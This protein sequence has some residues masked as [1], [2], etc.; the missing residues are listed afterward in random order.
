MFKS[1]SILR[2]ALAALVIL[3]LLP[4]CAPAEEMAPQVYIA[5]DRVNMLPLAGAIAYQAE[6]AGSSVDMLSIFTPKDGTFYSSK[7]DCTLSDGLQLFEGKKLSASDKVSHISNFLRDFAHNADFSSPQTEVYILSG[8]ERDNLV[9]SSWDKNK[10]EFKNS[11]L[12]NA[13]QAL[14]DVMDT[15]PGLILHFRYYSQKKRNETALDEKL[16][17][18]YPDRVTFDV[19]PE[20]ISCS[21]LISR[22]F[23][24][25]MSSHVTR[26]LEGSL[27]P[28]AGIEYDVKGVSEVISITFAPDQLPTSVSF[29]FEDV[30]PAEN[31]DQLD[32]SKPY[33]DA[34]PLTD[35][36]DKAQFDET[37][38]SAG[39]S[40]VA[41]AS[42]DNAVQLDQDA[43]T[44]QS[45]TAAEAGAADV[46]PAAFMIE[47]TSAEAQSNS[48]IPADPIVQPEETAIADDATQTEHAAS[49]HA[50]DS[51]FFHDEDEKTNTFWLCLPAGTQDGRINVVYDSEAP[52]T[53][54]Y[55]LTTWAE[56]PEMQFTLLDSQKNPVDSSATLNLYSEET[57]LTLELKLP[58]FVSEDVS[59]SL[60]TLLPQEGSYIESPLEPQSIHAENDLL[61]WEY[62]LEA[63]PPETSGRLLLGYSIWE[64]SVAENITLQFYVENRPPVLAKEL[65]N[66]I[67]FDVYFDVPGVKPYKQ[68]YNLN[69][70]FCDPDFEDSISFAVKPKHSIS[71]EYVISDDILTYIAHQ[72]VSSPVEVP[73]TITDKYG[74]TKEYSFIFT[75]HSMENKLKQLQMMP[76]KT[77]SECL[78]GNSF[79][80]P[81]GE[82]TVLRFVLPAD[83]Y[84]SLSRALED[85][86]YPTQKNCLNLSADGRPISFIE[87]ASGNLIFSVEQIKSEISGYFPLSLDAEFS[88]ASS[89]DTDASANKQIIKLQNF[90]GGKTYNLSFYNNPPY[91]KAGV[92][93]SFDLGTHDI[94]GLPGNYTPIKLSDLPADPTV[95]DAPIGPL[96]L[97][98]LFENIEAIEKLTYEIFVSCDSISIQDSSDSNA[99]FPVSSTN[100]CILTDEQASRALEIS[101]LEPGEYSIDIYAIDSENQS[102]SV[103]Y[104]VTLKSSFL[105]L[106]IISVC[107]AAVLLIL[108]II[109]LIIRQRLKPSFSELKM[110]I[111]NQRI[112]NRQSSDEYPP[113][114][115]L[116]LSAYKKESVSLMRLLI[117]AGQLPPRTCMNHPDVLTD[118]T[119]APHK[120]GDV[121]VIRSSKSKNV[122]LHVE[123]QEQRKDNRFELKTGQLL[124]ICFD[125]AETIF[126]RIRN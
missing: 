93:N 8:Y 34:Q 68:A 113:Q 7:G 20:D 38:L 94:D 25:D 21:E 60:T 56:L 64:Q 54:A 75:H 118:I 6:Q 4:V 67:A 65:E 92:E 117:A 41:E 51:F 40:T 14:C 18:R 22:T 50:I 47:A 78:K 119:F 81:I 15:H 123:G 73:I 114:N 63:L 72:Q 35:N 71:H 2:K 125:Q 28:D 24:A 97:S 102:A 39:E 80:L 33:D 120:S 55:R 76:D 23:T 49:V 77:S 98:N 101:L 59:T 79:V 122:S 115:E 53:A 31:S 108:L 110:S 62:A 37:A 48:V 84:L 106:V 12:R 13:Y 11:Y 52:E 29:V 61:R 36:S 91:L 32:L 100:P 19:V 46:Q 111:S 57:L 10:D 96:Q 85:L 70:Y 42:I 90:F 30:L 43:I 69:D 9:F 103:S 66:P 88:Y 104:Q 107:I 105:R 124:S 45:A 99:S 86:N 116:N 82:E 87:D 27:A 5:V 74:E 17:E 16:K 89:D 1:M 126:I 83:A 109:A 95:S 58:G 44:A 121:R 3:L 26:T 112:E